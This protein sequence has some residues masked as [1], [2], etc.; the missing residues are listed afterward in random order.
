ML[1]RFFSLQ[2]LIIQ[3]HKLRCLNF[4]ENDNE[5]R[6]WSKQIYL[7]TYNQG[8]REKAK[9]MVSK[10]ILIFLHKFK[11][12]MVSLY[13]FPLVDYF[14]MLSQPNIYIYNL[15]PYEYFFF[16]CLDQFFWSNH[17]LHISITIGWSQEFFDITFLKKIS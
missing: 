6:F 10:C 17:I 9:K 12:L 14:T 16:P 5:K 8:Q 11:V 15:K 7:Y 13:F 2:I 3:I 1:Y 4:F